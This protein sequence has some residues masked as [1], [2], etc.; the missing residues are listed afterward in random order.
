M[1][2]EADEHPVT[3]ALSESPPAE[4]PVG[5][6]LV[7]AVRVSSPSGTDLRGGRVDVMAAEKMA[8]THELLR[9]AEGQDFS[10]TEPFTLRAPEQIGEHVW[11]VLFPR[12]EIDGVVYQQS[13]LPVSFRTKPHATSLAVWDI[14]S[15][16][17][18]GERFNIKVG[19]KST[20]DCLLKGARVDIVDETG[21]TAGSGTLGQ[22]PWPGTTALFWTEVAVRAPADERIW[23]WSV[24]FAADDLALPHD[25]VSGSFSF[26]T[27]LPPDHV[28]TIIAVVQDSE[29]AVRDAEVRL[30][31]HR[32]ATDEVG[33]AR[34][35]VPDG[36]YDLIVWKVGY[37]MSSRK[38]E[39]TRDVTIRVEGIELP[40]KN[41][42]GNW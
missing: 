22:E 37:E 2:V 4:I 10:E 28:V 17:V 32:G 38:V 40:P 13:R 14:P 42:Y 12:Q 29:V 19:A 9:R 41:P 20:A 23:S 1:A 26:S 7:L 21:A 18:T 33:I 30:G 8:A 16:V 27:T 34:L 5:A 24:R 6:A 15:P 11:T 35:A 36:T 31:S 3:I 39:V 25:G